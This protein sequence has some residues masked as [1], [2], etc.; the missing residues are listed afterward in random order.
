MRY[1]YDNSLDARGKPKH[2][3]L[4][5]LNDTGEYKKL[6]GTSSVVDVLS[7]VLTWWASG[8]A[9]KTL[10]WIHP[11]IKKGGKKV[12]SVPL[13]DRLAAAE[14]ML[15][16]IKMM[17]PQEYLDLLDK[18]YKA[19]SVKLDDTA[20]A[21]TDLHAELEKFVKWKMTGKL[22]GFTYN[23]RIAPFVDW[24][25]HAVKKFIW[26]EVHCFH[27]VLWVGGISDVGAI[28]NGHTIETEDGPIEVPDGTRAVIDFKSAKEYYTSQF[29][30]GAGYALQVEK[31]GLLDPDG[32]KIGELDGPIQAIVI[33]AFGKE[34]VYP[35]VRMQA[36]LYKEAFELCLRLY[37]I[38][39]MDKSEYGK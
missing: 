14:K 34:V 28:L 31:N 5:D 20:Q 27:E 32:N 10:G 1:K 11:D 17:S 9:V 29:I 12:G 36:D 24:S 13:A 4:L 30:Q 21:G 39:G 6:T 26:S 16:L 37:R 22:N 23:D 8:E 19:H 2:T 15:A 18:A 3:H 7:K 38:L 33:V 25:S 35:E